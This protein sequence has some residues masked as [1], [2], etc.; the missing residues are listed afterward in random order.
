MTLKE[1]YDKAKQEPTPAMNFIKEVMAV[2]HKSEITV[3][4]WLAGEVVPDALTCA[5]L[6]EHFGCDP[7]ELFEK[8]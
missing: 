4:R 6:A 7:K 8:A 5:V 1:L 3:R 2:T